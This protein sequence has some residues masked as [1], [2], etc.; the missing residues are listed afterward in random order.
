MSE[1]SN[2]ASKMKKQLP[3]EL[4]NFMQVAGEITQG[5]GQRLY[6]VGGVVRDLLLGRGNLD[7]DLVVEGDAINLAQQLV[8]INQA[9]IITHARFGTA[10]LQ[11]DEWSVD[12]VTA[13]SE[14]YIRP[15][16]LPT[17]KPGSINSDI[18][19]RDFT[20]NAMAV[21]LNSGRY[22]ELLD[23]YEGRSDLERKLIRVL[24]EKSFIDDA[25]RIW[26]SLR[27][28]QRLDF[29]LEEATRQLLKRAVPMLDTISGDRIRHELELVLREELPEKCLH[30][31]DE[32]GVLARLHPSLKRDGWLA[33]KFAQARKLTAPDLPAVGFYLALLA[34]RL[35]A[36][37]SER[38]IAYL[39]LPKAVAQTLR[40][41]IGV[42]AKLESL[43]VSGLAPSSIYSLL[44]DYCSPALLANSLAAA[45]PAAVEHIR[46]FLSVFRYVK[47][48]LSG[49]NLKKMGVDEGPRIKEILNLLRE[50]RLDGKVS[51]RKDEE[52]L[53]EEWL[54]R[55]GGQESG[56]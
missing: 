39:R 41:T 11:W 33:E 38:L 47:P 24:H 49:K 23:L 15:G 35:T 51:S 42:K 18:F 31:A 5:Q 36:E 32:L 53:V 4:I 54:T 40:D 30:R 52:R 8:H 46:L 1:T 13:R 14:T 26:R 44:H 10:K 25:T 6:L 17:V 16:A 55:A 50:A 34:Y 45:S 12:I 37:E 56:G 27:Y 2:L 28:E 29:Q 7:L 22:G 43:S 9:K 19:R 21:E 3:A 20:I 48:V